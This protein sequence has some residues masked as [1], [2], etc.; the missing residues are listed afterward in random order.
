VR[1]AASAGDAQA[2]LLLGASYDPTVLRD[3]G[4]LGFAPDPGQARTWYQ[5]AAD[6]GLPEAAR[7]LERLVKT[8]R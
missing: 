3:L 1:R 6:A 2:A 8:A 7:R 4:V 5:K